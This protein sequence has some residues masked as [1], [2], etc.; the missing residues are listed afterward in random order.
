MYTIT[1]HNI[2]KSQEFKTMIQLTSSLNHMK[3]LF[4]LYSKNGGNIDEFHLQSLDLLNGYL[5]EI[6]ADDVILKLGLGDDVI[7]DVYQ[8]MRLANEI[9]YPLPP[10]C[11]LCQEN[12]LLRRFSTFKS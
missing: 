8:A 3:R 5:K 10:I 2:L 6:V 12:I 4:V 9:S 11:F 1:K 7:E